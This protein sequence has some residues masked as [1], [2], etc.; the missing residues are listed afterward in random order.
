MPRASESVRV[1]KRIR[2]P[3]LSLMACWPLVLRTAS[4]RALS[5]G[6]SSS[7]NGLESSWNIWSEVSPCWHVYRIFSPLRAP[8]KQRARTSQLFPFCRGMDMPIERSRYLSRPSRASMASSRCGCHGSGSPKYADASSAAIGPSPS[9]FSGIF[10]SY[11]GVC[12][13]CITRRPPWLVPR[14]RRT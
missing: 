12:L 4:S 3:F 5:S 8:W 2:P 6:S 11:V 10:A 1:V 9:S 14:G 13:A 7:S